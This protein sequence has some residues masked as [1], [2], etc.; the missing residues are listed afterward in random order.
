[1]GRVNGLVPCRFLTL[2]AHLVIVITIFWTRDSNVQASL[3]PNFSKEE[4]DEEDYWGNSR[5]PLS[6]HRLVTALCITLGLFL[7]E[8]IGFFSGVTM[9]HSTQSLFSIGVHCCAAVSLA[10]F[11]FERWEC[12]AYCVLPA[13]TEVVMMISVFA[14]KRKSF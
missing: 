9:F 7:I 8:L 3:T 5:T 10:F 14:L 6:L 4:Y 2:L 1:M 12:F 11:V 13:F